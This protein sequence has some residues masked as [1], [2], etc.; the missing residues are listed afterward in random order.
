VGTTAEGGCGPGGYGPV[1]EIITIYNPRRRRVAVERHQGTP[2]WRLVILAGWGM[3]DAELLRAV[4]PLL[5]PEEIALVTRALGLED[6]QD[7]QP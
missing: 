4:R 5:E 7:P 6:R 2:P 1:V 3:A